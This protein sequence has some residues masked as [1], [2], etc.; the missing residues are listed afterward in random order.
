MTVT[1]RKTF[2]LFVQAGGPIHYYGH[3]RQ[4]RFQLGVDQEP[5]TVFAY[6]VGEAFR[7]GDV[8]PGIRLEERYRASRIEVGTG[9]NG[10]GHD[11]AI[12]SEVEQLFSIA[13]PFGLF[14]A[15][16]RHLPLSIAR[17]ERK[18][19]KS[20][21]VRFHSKHMRPICHPVK[22]GPH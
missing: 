11:L 1:A 15:R 2:Q 12:R 14:P 21:I 19:R 3:W 5:L 10:R 16:A 8:F 4:C 17:Q 20:P 7:R 18:L 22:T 13:S 6:I 9:G